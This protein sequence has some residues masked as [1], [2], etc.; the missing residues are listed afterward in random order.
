MKGREERAHATVR[1]WQ[2]IKQI[3]EQLT[4]I[5]CLRDRRFNFKAFHY[6]SLNALNSVTY[7]HPR[8]TDEDWDTKR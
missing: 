4:V 2:V 8:F 6:N 3:G 5:E 1:G 7:Y